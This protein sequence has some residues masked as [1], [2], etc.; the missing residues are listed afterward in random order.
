MSTEVFYPRCSS[1]MVSPTNSRFYPSAHGM[2]LTQLA[3]KLL[4]ILCIQL[5]LF[6]SHEMATTRE[7]G[8]VDQV[9]L[10]RS[11]LTR[12]GRI[13]GTMGHGCR[14]SFTLANSAATG[15]VHIFVI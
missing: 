4:H 12:Q 15:N 11:P 8:E 5:R 13:V 10:A 9:D 6:P 7:F 3:H 14:N 1:D 2:L